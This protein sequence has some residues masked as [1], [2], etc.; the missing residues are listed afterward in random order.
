[1]RTAAGSAASRRVCASLDSCRGA[2]AG[3]LVCLGLCFSVLES[4][5]F[6]AGYR[7]VG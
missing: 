4:S 7:G 2:A 3:V 5:C 1:M 6:Q